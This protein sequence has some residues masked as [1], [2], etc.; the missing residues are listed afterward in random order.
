VTE[1]AA[2]VLAAAGALWTKA[3]CLLPSTVR[4]RAAEHDGGA[5]RFAVRAARDGAPHVDGRVDPLD[6]T[7]R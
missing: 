7:R 1:A 5:I 3:R 6:A 2:R 4:F